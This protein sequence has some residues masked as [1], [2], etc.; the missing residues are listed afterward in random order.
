MTLTQIDSIFIPDITNH[1]KVFGEI[2]TG[3]GCGDP[4]YDSIL[5]P[6]IANTPFEAYDFPLL[7]TIHPKFTYG[8]DL[9]GL[10]DTGKCFSLPQSRAVQFVVTHDIPN[11]GTTFI[12]SLFTD[13]TDENLAQAFL[14]GQGA[15]DYLLYCDFLLRTYTWGNSARWM[16]SFAKPVVQKEIAFNNACAG[17]AWY[18]VFQSPMCLVGGRG[19]K[20]I[21]CV[22]KS[23]QATTVTV[24]ASKIKISLT[25]SPQ[26]ILGSKATISFAN[27][28]VKFVMPARSAGMWLDSAMTAVNNSKY[29]CKKTPAFGAIVIRYNAHT[30]CLQIFQQSTHSNF[31]ISL[32]D[33]IG[34]CIFHANNISFDQGMATI[35][36]KAINQGIYFAVVKSPNSK[37][38]LMFVK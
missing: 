10:L 17:K 4:G 31:S 34:R 36:V 29:A 7:S 24:P 37:S 35:N 18:A 8:G 5:Q 9:T 16:N 13:T 20:G 26:E 23:T 3:G 19:D 28:S 33:P 25:N 22:N 27:D 11:N 2:I 21:F 32:N 14:L 12:G 1:C 6:F 38:S 30:G 15:G